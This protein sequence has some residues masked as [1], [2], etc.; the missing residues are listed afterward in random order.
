[1]KSTNPNF[2]SEFLLPFKT[3]LPFYPLNEAA[4][5]HALN[6]LFTP[7]W[8]RGCQPSQ[9]HLPL[10]KGWCNPYKQ[11]P[12]P[13]T[14]AGIP[15]LSAA[16]RFGKAPFLLAHPTWGYSPFTARIEPFLCRDFHEKSKNS[17]TKPNLLAEF[18]LLC[19]LPV[20]PQPGTIP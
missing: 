4:L 15:L 12:C 14:G 1:M 13:F 20:A 11:L 10:A 5:T 19:L 7:P 17:S 6:L 2:H 9:E 16:E 8:E 18:P 3:Q